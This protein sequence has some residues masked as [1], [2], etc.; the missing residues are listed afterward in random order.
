VY[1]LSIGDKSVDLGR[2]LVYFFG[3]QNLYTM[4]ITHTF[5]Q[6]TTKFDSVRGLANQNLFPWISSALVRGSCDNHV[7]TRISSP[8]LPYVCR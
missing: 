1:I 4:D 6:S 7:A 2:T 8:S 3:E 5:C